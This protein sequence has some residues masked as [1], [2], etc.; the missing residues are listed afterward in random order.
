MTAHKLLPYALYPTTWIV[1]LLLVAML[2]SWRS[3]KSF[4]FAALLGATAVTL[5]FASPATANFLWQSLES[6]YPPQAV[7]T[8]PRADAIVLLG[9]GV[10]LPAPPRL[11]PDLN[12]SADRLWLAAEL[13]HA[14]KAPL[15]VVSGGQ[16]FAQPGLKSEADYHVALLERL[17]VPRDA[18]MLET[19]SRN[20]Q[21]NADYVAQRLRQRGL[22]RVLLTT[23]AIHMPRAML[24]FERAGLDATAAVCDVRV[25]SLDGPWLLGIL[26]SAQALSVSEEAIREWLGYFYYRIR[27]MPAARS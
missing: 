26:P 3:R 12:D 13:Y 21:Q 15:V 16:V 23:S 8:L 10:G 6:R 25:V 22:T 14:G 7:D 17:G 11:A 2:L 27:A 4:A 1:L 20:T 9:G 24:L 19:D 5:I 18:I